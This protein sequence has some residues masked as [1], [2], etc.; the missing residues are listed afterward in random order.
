MRIL[1]EWFYFECIPHE[2]QWKGE[3]ECYDKFMQQRPNY[4][5]IWLYYLVLTFKKLEKIKK[6]FIG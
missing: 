4:L 6:I 1:S 5:K 3:I 2:F